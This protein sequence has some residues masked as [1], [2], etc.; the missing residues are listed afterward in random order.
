MF[1]GRVDY[2]IVSGKQGICDEFFG[3]LKQSC[4]VKNL[5]EVKTHTGS[6]FKRNWDKIILEMNQAVFAE[7]IVEQY[8]IS[9][10]SNIL[11]KPRCRSQAQKR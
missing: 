3:Q 5:R 4:P 2:M 7:N 9:T 1:S 11:V 8:K 6:A 10:T